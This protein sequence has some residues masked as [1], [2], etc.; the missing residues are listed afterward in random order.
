MKVKISEVKNRLSSALKKRG[1]SLKDAG[2]IADEYISGEVEGKKSHGLMAFPSLLN[3]LA[4]NRKPY[5]IIKETHSLIFIEANKN[6]GGLIANLIIPKLVKMAKKEGVAI[7]CIRNMTT[8]L[9]PGFVAELVSDKNMIGIVVNN[10]GRP[11]TAPFGGYTPVIGTNPIGIGIPTK[12]NPIVADM[13][14]SKLAWGEVRKAERNKE[15]LPANTFL[16]KNGVFTRNPKEA[17]SVIPMGDYKGFAIGLL[18]EILAGSFLGRNMDLSKFKGDYRTITRG[19]IIMVLN[20]SKTTNVNSFKKANT[21][22]I[23]R[24]KKSRRRKGA[25]RILFPGEKDAKNR[26]TIMQ[27]GKIDID[28]EL[29]ENLI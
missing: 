12:H 17:R 21:A 4:A 15:K 1:F 19:G 28:K 10:G 13:A 3:R 14:T 26:K 2:L 29:W 24:V 25:G 27:K 5:K 23:D 18:I 7:A 22:L 8:W 16:N 11:M 6:L 20:P 9:R